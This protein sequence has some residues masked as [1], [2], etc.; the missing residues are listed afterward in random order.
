MVARTRKP[1]RKCKRNLTRDRSGLCEKCLDIHGNTNWQQWKQKTG[2]RHKQGYGTAWQK[3]RSVV[4]ERDEHLCTKCL[5]EGVLT[6]ATHVD[7]I[8]PKSQGGSEELSN[9]QALCKDCHFK[10]TARER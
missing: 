2:N 7:H 8:V 3:T 9:L 4:L 6:Q 5:T 10:K 1:C